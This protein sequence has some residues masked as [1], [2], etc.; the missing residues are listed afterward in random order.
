MSAQGQFRTALRRANRGKEYSIDFE[1]ITPAVLDGIR[2]FLSSERSALIDF[3]EEFTDFLSP[4]KRE[5]VVD[6]ILNQFQSFLDNSLLIS[7]GRLAVEGPKD[8][9]TKTMADVFEMENE[10]LE[11]WFSTNKQELYDMFI[12]GTFR[13]LFN[14]YAFF[15]AQGLENE[16]REIISTVE[17][18]PSVDENLSLLNDKNR[19]KIQ[20]ND[21]PILEAFRQVDSSRFKE[22][23]EVLG[24]EEALPSYELEPLTEMEINSGM[25]SRGTNLYDLL[26]IVLPANQQ[27]N[28]PS[29]ALREVEN[30]S[31][32]AFTSFV[33]RLYRGTINDGVT[34]FT[35]FS[36]LVSRQAVPE[37]RPRVDPETGEAIETEE[38][39][40]KRKPYE[41]KFRLGAGD[42]IPTSKQYRDFYD[43]LKPQEPY[44]EWI[45]TKDTAAFQ[46]AL[47]AFL[48]RS[49]TSPNV[50]IFMESFMGN[51]LLSNYAASMGRKRRPLE[52]NF[53]V[54]PSP[55]NIITSL[56][57]FIQLFDESYSFA[58]IPPFFRMEIETDE[59]EVIPSE[60]EKTE[61]ML[62]DKL[63]EGLSILKESIVGEINKVLEIMM[64]R[65]TVQYKS[66]RNIPTFKFLDSMDLIALED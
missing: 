38:E 29:L 7:L 2:T 46:G 18:N 50:N 30:L 49:G 45:R 48:R 27:I 15:K 33:R 47:D 26:S 42:L 20:G 17:T 36:N 8:N 12:G 14:T 57:G 6:D 25:V 19:D 63:T 11:G 10:T 3:A 5:E 23:L 60:V 61:A 56:V 16:Y 52:G 54:N 62:N 66:A 35:Q 55:D 41:G 21:P 22:I 58:N 28:Y 39:A 64:E 13:P 65:P 43:Y 9:P 4:E 34:L 59:G 1:E 53:E 40:A 32:E 51:V 37:Y 24:V 31:L 44:E